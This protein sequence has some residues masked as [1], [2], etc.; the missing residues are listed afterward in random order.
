MKKKTK[1]IQKQGR[2]RPIARI[3]SDAAEVAFLG[4]M[5][6][7][8][9]DNEKLRKAFRKCMPHLYSL[10]NKGCSWTQITDLLNQVGI[11]LLSSTVRNYYY[12]MLTG[13]TDIRQDGK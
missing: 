7:V 5:K 3:N 10:R 12:E 4:V 1:K 6:G 2:K 8:V 9:P 13:I 11:K